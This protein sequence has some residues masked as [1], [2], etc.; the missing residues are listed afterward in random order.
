MFNEAGYIDRAHNKIKILMEKNE[1]VKKY[2]TAT[3]DLLSPMIPKENIE[4]LLLEFEFFKIINFL[5]Q[6]LNLSKYSLRSLL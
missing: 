2:Y 1:T 5:V 3:D 4:K 6:N